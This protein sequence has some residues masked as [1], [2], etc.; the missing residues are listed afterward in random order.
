MNAHGY[1]KYITPWCGSVKTLAT[2]GGA[3]R[4]G[5]GNGRNHDNFYGQQH[6]EGLCKHKKSNFFYMVGQRST[7]IINKLEK[8]IF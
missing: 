3:T 7:L 8:Y 5:P 2:P 1:L 6:V 4:L